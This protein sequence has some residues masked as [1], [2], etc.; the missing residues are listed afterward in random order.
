M[1]LD[2]PDGTA[3]FVDANIVH[4]ALVQGMPFSSQCLAF[5]DRTIAGYVQAATAAFVMA[6]AVHK[7]ML[8]EA[9]S[10]SPQPRTGLVAWLKH[11]PDIVRQLQ[12]P[13][14]AAREIARL[15]FRF[16][17]VDVAV[18]EA[19]ARISSEHGLLTNDAVIVALMR[20]HDLTHIVTNDDD[21]DRIPELTVWK[22]R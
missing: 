1:P 7:T 16:L 3:C 6:D 9:I 17:T 12:S 2:I 15:S 21:F 19:A 11:N 22:P 5:L 8:S 18:L 13:P 4:Y 14:M 10:I 20:R